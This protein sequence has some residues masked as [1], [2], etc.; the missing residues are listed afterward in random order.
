M[1][2]NIP[3]KL[4]AIELLRKEN[5]FIMNESQA[6]SQDIRPLKIL[7]VNLM[8]LKIITETDLIR[9]LSNTPLQIE[10]DFMRMRNRESK[11]T[12]IEHLNAFYQTFEDIKN[13]NYDGMIITGAPV[14]MMPFEDVSYWQELTEIFNWSKDH[15]TSSLFI[16]WGAQAALYHFYKIPKYILSQ[17]IFGVFNHYNTQN[18]LPIFRGFDDS[19]FVPHSRHTEILEQDILSIKELHIIAK[20]EQSGVHIVMDNQGKQFFITG[21]HEYSRYTLDNE[22]KRD[23]AKNL[24]IHIPENYYP[25]DNPVKEPMM[26]WKGHGNLLFS[27]WLNYYVYQKT[28]YNFAQR[29]GN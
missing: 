25:E 3:D 12:P 18:N 8:P 9:L 5:I 19:Y 11:N 16:C 29:K 26:L 6:Q 20:S 10:I 24:T 21:H 13:N 1:P 22:Y 7:I 15:V 2:I 23:I 17:K 14:E 4:P 27:N 28:P